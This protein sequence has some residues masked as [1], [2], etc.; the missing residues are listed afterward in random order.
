[1]KNKF[2]NS[3][4]RTKER[5]RYRSEIFKNSECAHSLG[6]ILLDVAGVKQVELNPKTGSLL[7]LYN[8]EVFDPI[9]FENTLNQEVN[10]HAP[11]LAEKQVKKIKR[12]KK[13][14]ELH[15]SENI[16]PEPL[17][18]LRRLKRKKGRLLETRSM[19]VFG[20][21]CLGGMFFHGW[22]IHKWAGW[23]FTAAA[24][25]HTWRYRKKVW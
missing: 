13:A 25:A 19:V 3:T 16:I 23:A 4:S 14:L 12:E 15:K 21:T 11:E 9:E 22:A 1:M 10:K 20:A 18:Q 24:A 8:I 5:L 6:K 2:V 7:V 17:S